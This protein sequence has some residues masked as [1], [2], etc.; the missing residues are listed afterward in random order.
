MKVIISPHNKEIRAIQKL[1]TKKSR[2]EQG[3][4]LAEGFRTC[5]TIIQSKKIK[6][7]QLYCVEESSE[8]AK[9][10]T[11]ISFITLISDE[12]MKKISP[13]ETPSGIVGVFNLPSK[14]PLEKISEG[15]V[16]AQV[17]DP[18]N[19][20][21]LIRTAAAMAYETVVVIEGCDI[22]APKVVQAS[23]GAIAKQNI[24]ELSWNELLNNKKDLKL[25]ALIVS[26]GRT[27]KHSKGFLI[28]IGNEAHGIPQEWSSQCDEKITLEMPGKTESLNAGVAGSIAMYLLKN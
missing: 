25:A 23:A 22:W 12:A 14:P 11:S 8:V 17:S 2:A 1:Q 15:I 19:A 28:V 16:L 6:L 24:F 13:V 10:L 9:Q 27:P 4:F 18:G 21:T 20:G 7:I 3:K 26:G 5:Q